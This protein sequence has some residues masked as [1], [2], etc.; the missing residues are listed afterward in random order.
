M[1]PLR[2]Q[3]SA[4]VLADHVP[5]TPQAVAKHLAA[6]DRVGLVERRRQGREVR[7]AARPDRLNTATEGMARR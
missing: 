2:H 3:A 4:S 7:Y 1:M 6:L 5:V